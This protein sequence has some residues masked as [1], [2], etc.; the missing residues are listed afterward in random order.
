MCWLVVFYFLLFQLASLWKGIENDILNEA[1]SEFQL[2]ETEIEH[3][4]KE[5]STVA[6]LVITN[7]GI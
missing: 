7:L 1:E 6:F 5:I 3:W 2:A 4:E